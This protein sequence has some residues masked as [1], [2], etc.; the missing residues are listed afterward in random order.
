MLQTKNQEN[1][2][3]SQG[4]IKSADANTKKTHMLKLSDKAFQ[5]A[6]IT[7]LHDV[8]KIH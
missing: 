3:T 5:T 6:A 2:T 1:V 8:K 7:M 4:K